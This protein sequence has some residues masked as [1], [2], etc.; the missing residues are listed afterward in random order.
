MES[1]FEQQKIK[2]GFHYIIGCDEVGRGCLAG[3]VVACSVIFKNVN[4]Q[5]WFHS[6]RDSKKLSATERERLSKIILEN[7]LAVG[8]G[9]ISPKEIDEMNIH[10]AS[11]L[12]MKKSIEKIQKN[13]SCE[14]EK[15]FLYVDGKFL[16][17]NISFSQ[18]AVVGGDDKVLSVAAASIV[19]K[20]Y[21]DNL[22]AKL[23]VKFP[24]YNFAQHKGYATAEHRQMIELHGLSEIHRLSFCSRFI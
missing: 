17:P 7:A 11:L 1:N 23:H 13:V 2:E 22:M 16:V 12:A 10:N 24:K 19:A 9:I 6:I 15:L 18:E 4:Q 20:V 5:P 3:P 14:S 8:I 21:R